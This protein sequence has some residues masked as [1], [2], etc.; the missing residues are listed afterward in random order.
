MCRVICWICVD[1]PE[2][3]A[4]LTIMVDEDGESRILQNVCSL[5][6]EH[7]PENVLVNEI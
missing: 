4:A 1:I 7:I 5:F 3:P 2:D 6:P